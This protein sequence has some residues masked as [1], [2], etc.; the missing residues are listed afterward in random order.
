MRKQRATALLTELGLGNK[1]QN[2]PSQLSGGQQQRVS[3]ARALMNGGD[4]ILAD[5]PT[6]ALDSHSGV[7]V[8]RILRE[9][10]A[11]GHTI[12]LVTQDMQV[13][14]NASRIIE[15]SDGQIIAD[16]VNAQVLAGLKEGDQVVIA[17]SSENSAASANS[18]N[19]RRNSPPMGM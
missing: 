12:I 17:D 7:E 14:K 1:T 9:L 3:I 8:M 5:E 6:G 13:A 15:I 2:R 11:A 16:R 18:S 10:N 4:V 19:R